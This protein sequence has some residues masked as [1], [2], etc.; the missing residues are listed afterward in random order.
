[1][2]I[3]VNR[4]TI[5]QLGKDFIPIYESVFDVWTMDGNCPYHVYLIYD[6]DKLIAFTSG[7]A[8]GLNTWYL[9]RAGFIKDEQGKVANFFRAAF[10]MDE[11]LKDWPYI[12]TFASNE[13]Q[14]ALKMLIALGFKIIGTRM[15]T[16][17]NLW[18]EFLKEKSNG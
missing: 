8:I 7:F 18:V 16:L 3:T 4:T 6:G 11:I 9:Q 5:D 10:C 17:R 2:T 15:D 1:M 12:M 13:N 14:K